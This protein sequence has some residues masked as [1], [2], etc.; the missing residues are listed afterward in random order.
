MSKTKTGKILIIKPT[1]SDPP[2]GYAYV[3]ACFEANCIPFD[4]IDSSRSDYWVKDVVIKLKHNKY[5]AVAMG[6]LV[7][8]YETFKTVV[9]LVR[10]YSPGTPFILGGNI[11]KDV[12]DSLLFERIGIDFGFVGEAETSIPQFMKALKIGNKDFSEVPG[13][14]YKSANG[15]I[16]RNT[17]KRLDLKHN[18]VRPAWHNFDMDYYI[19]HTSVPFIGRDLQFMPVLSGRG[20][21][22]QCGFCSPTIGGFRK[23]LID[24]V[25]AEIEDLNSKYKFKC[26]SFHNEMFYPTAREIR[27]FCHRYKSLKNKKPWI[28]QV[29]IDAN[30]DTQTFIEMREAG[31]MVVSTGIES[32]SD[33]VLKCMKKRTTADQIK[34]F[35]QSARLAKMPINGAF[36]VGYENET[37]EDLKKTIDLVID[38]KINAGE[39][40]MYVYPGTAVYENALQKGSIEDEMVY[41]EKATK[42]GTGNIFSSFGKKDYFNVSAIPDYD[43]FRIATREVRRYHTFVFT[44]YPVCDL[45]SQIKINNTKALI[46]MKGQCHKCNREVNYEH[47]IF[48]GVEYAGFLGV[49]ISNRNICP[50]CFS[51]LSFDL[52]KCDNDWKLPQHFASLKEHIAGKNRIVVAGINKDLDFL[53]HINLL[54][55][56]YERILGIV[57]L[58]R[59]YVGDWYN[60][61]SMLSVKKA[62]ELKP[63][64]ILWLGLCS[65]TSGILSKFKRETA[66]PPVILYL[67][68]KQ[69]QDSLEN[70]RN[71]IK[72]KGGILLL[73]QRLLRYIEGNLRMFRQICKKNNIVIPRFIEKLARS[74]KRKF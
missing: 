71:E 66:S 74:F 73:L 28:T 24:D 39:S 68:S 38:E 15:K 44:H 8:F 25:I 56:D 46:S 30:I 35:C 47:E 7:G 65:D 62:V 45:T 55:M 11:V 14:V 4:F 67:Y 69:L 48:H 40:L 54:N 52:Y 70:V 43:F 12:N 49:G 41:L 13:L 16:I 57:P 6:G 50:K 34:N 3:L 59:N 10:K 42:I 27:E 29:R 36:I 9:D 22:G 26:I 60:I 32:G 72:S 64:C 23:R 53:L 21:V 31:C 33:R 19:S 61:Y 18:N 51:Q 5:L 20:C 1:Y 2:I 17:P 63:D 37:E 58:D